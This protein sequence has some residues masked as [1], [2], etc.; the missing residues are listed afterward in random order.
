M[1]CGS[2]KIQSSIIMLLSHCSLRWLSALIWCSL[3]SLYQHECDCWHWNETKNSL[4]KS[5]KQS[6]LHY[7]FFCRTTLWNNRAWTCRA[8]PLKSSRKGGQSPLTWDRE[9]SGSSPGTGSVRLTF[10]P[11]P[12]RWRPSC[13]LALWQTN[14]SPL[15]E[16]KWAHSSGGSHW[17]TGGEVQH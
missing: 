16:N 17:Q 3:A 12:A 9:H 7:I 15:S 5:S 13:S 10:M 8:P 2:G 4:M 1:I 14:S 11:S 6:H